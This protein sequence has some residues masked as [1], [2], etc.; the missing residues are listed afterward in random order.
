MRDATYNMPHTT[1]ECTRPPACLPLLCNL[2]CNVLRLVWSAQC[3]CT[4]AS[5][6]TPR[7]PVL[8]DALNSS[9]GRLNAGNTSGDSDP[10][11][12]SAVASTAAPPAGSSGVSEG[13][14]DD[15][16]LSLSPGG[17]GALLAQVGAAARPSG[18]A[19]PWDIRHDNTP[20]HLTLERTTGARRASAHRTTRSVPGAGAHAAGEMLRSGRDRPPRCASVGGLRAVPARAPVRHAAVDRINHGWCMSCDGLSCWWGRG[21]VTYS[22]ARRRGVR[23]STHGRRSSRAAGDSAL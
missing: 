17:S 5:T 9:L 1:Y 12:P 4:N 18:A 20:H 14:S 10:F 11:L 3:R 7:A 2:L 16:T 23:S 19:Q 8:S 6:A 21:V 22:A 15:G 13:G